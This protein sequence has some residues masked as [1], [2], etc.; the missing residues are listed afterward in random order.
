MDWLPTSLSPMS[1]AKCI[2]SIY[3]EAR[4]SGNI[5]RN[6]NIGT[7]ASSTTLEREPIV[8]DNF[9]GLG[10]LMLA[11]LEVEYSD[12]VEQTMNTPFW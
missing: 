6:A 8:T 12:T 10:P 2:L 3:A 9:Q 4:A 11:A 1:K 7:E 5:T